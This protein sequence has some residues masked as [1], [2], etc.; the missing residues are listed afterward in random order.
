MV[1]EVIRSGREGHRLVYVVSEQQ[2]AASSHDDI[3]FGAIGSTFWN[4]T[5]LDPWTDPVST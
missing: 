4:A 3:Q 1:K 2:K 5:R